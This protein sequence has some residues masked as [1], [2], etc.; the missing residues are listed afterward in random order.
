MKQKQLLGL[1]LAGLCLMGLA[2]K[3]QAALFADA[4]APANWQ[5]R[6]DSPSPGTFIFT[7]TGNAEILELTGAAVGSSETVVVI[8]SPYASSPAILSFTWTVV[9]NGNIGAPEAAYLVDNVP[10][11]LHGPGGTG[12]GLIL[13]EGTEFGFVLGANPE[14]GKNP[15]VFAITDWEAQMVPETGTWLAAALALGVALVEWRRRQPSKTV[16]PRL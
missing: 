13:P 16:V 4:F 1:A 12:S 7:G 15:P 2:G 10:T 5:I 8:K 11:P 3:L 6:P 14:S 9:N